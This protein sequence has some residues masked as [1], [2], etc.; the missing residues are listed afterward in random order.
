MRCCD[1][2]PQQVWH[3]T[4]VL[5]RRPFTVLLKIFDQIVDVELAEGL[6][7]RR[8]HVD[9]RLLHLQH[10]A[11]GIGELVELLVER[12]ADRPGALD[13]VLVVV[14]LDRERRSARAGWC[15]T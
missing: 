3:Q 5:A 7:A 8:H 9:L 2:L 10:R 1:G 11:A 4:S 6:A 13:R 15:R 14:V 12:V